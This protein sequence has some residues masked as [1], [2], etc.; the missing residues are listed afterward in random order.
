MNCFGR[1][2]DSK[3]QIQFFYLPCFVCLGNDSMV[4]WLLERGANVHARDMNNDT[5]LLVAARAG[6]ESTVKV[7]VHA[8]DMNN[9]TPLLVAARAGKESTVKVKIFG[10]GLFSCNWFHDK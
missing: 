7:N 6:K 4:E 2:T 5:P 9:D 3:Q 8:R 10:G 1:G